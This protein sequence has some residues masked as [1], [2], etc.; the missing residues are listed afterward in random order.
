MAI[1]STTYLYNIE[2][3]VLSS[4]LYPDAL[5]FKI[6]SAKALL[7]ILIEPHYSERDDERITAVQRAIKF[8]ESL[9][10]ELK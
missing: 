1:H 2:P 7:G 9:L 3:S 5:K 4:M 10:S 8:N 6:T